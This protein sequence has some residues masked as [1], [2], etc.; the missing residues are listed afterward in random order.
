MT[1]DVDSGKLK[2]A[3]TLV[4]GGIHPQLI[5]RATYPRVALSNSGRALPAWRVRRSE[6]TIR[7]SE[8]IPPAGVLR[9]ITGHGRHVRLRRAEPYYDEH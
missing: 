3:M 5:I 9:V 4:P 2:A 7:A 6:P 8:N 1:S